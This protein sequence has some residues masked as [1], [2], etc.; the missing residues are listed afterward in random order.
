MP[1]PGPSLEDARAKLMERDTSTVTSTIPIRTCYNY[2]EPSEDK[3]GCQCEGFE[4]MDFNAWGG[5]VPQPSGQPCSAISQVTSVTT[6]DA[7]PFTST[8]INDAVLAYATTIEG[9]GFGAQV[10]AGANSTILAGSSF[11]LQIG[12]ST[13][14]QVG[15]MTEASQISSLYVSSSIS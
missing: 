10:G 12:A 4:D 7:Y 13:S 1:T 6:S 5:F 2:Q 11:S 9:I 15:S 8:L 14:V 3:R